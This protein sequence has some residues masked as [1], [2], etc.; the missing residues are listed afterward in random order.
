VHKGN[1]EHLSNRAEFR[2]PLCATL[3]TESEEVKTRHPAVVLALSETGGEFSSQ[4]KVVPGEAV[5]VILHPDLR[6]AIRGRVTWTRQVQKRVHTRFGV[7]FEDEIPATLW[8]V[9]E[10]TTAA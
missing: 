1:S 8:D 7:A 9:L 2:L 10:Q 3:L 6:Y 4:K 5:G